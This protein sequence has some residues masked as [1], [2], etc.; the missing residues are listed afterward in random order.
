MR[1]DRLLSLL[2]LLQT[3]GR[4]TAAD[5]AAELEVTE[6]TIYRDLTALSTAG[7]PVYAERGPGGGCSLLEDYRTTLTGLTPDEQRALLL[8]NIPAPLE[9]L[10]FSQELKQALLKLRA[11]LPPARLADLERSANRVHLDA[12]WWFQGSQPA[13]FLSIIQ[14]AVWQDVRLRLQR[15]TF[16]KHVINE[17]VDA[18]G[19]VAK[20]GVWYLVYRSA[21]HTRALRLSY[22]LN[23]EIVPEKFLRPPDFNLADFWETWCRDYESSR[24]DYPV[25][26]RIAPALLPE[27]ASVFGQAV[28]ET[29]N[30]APPE[31]DGWRVILLRYESLEDARQHLLAL[32]SAVEVLKPPALRR[33]MQDFGEQILNIYT[34]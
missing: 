27:L 2:M 19:L 8:I 25:L 16:L 15:Q 29:Y 20:A 23:A 10:G 26:V 22:L 17:T 6:R 24:P 12:T 30:S 14:Q 5:L 11:S 13:P 33:S 7:V 1:A 32:G 34:Q 31:P 4:M 3:R 28:R 9:Q 21:D 18:L